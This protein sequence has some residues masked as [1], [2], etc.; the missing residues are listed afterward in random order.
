MIH[1]YASTIP[2]ILLY[3][4]LNIG[5]QSVCELFVSFVLLR[6]PCFG[7][8]K[9]PCKKCREGL[10]KKTNRLTV[11]L[12]QI[13]FTYINMPAPAIAA[14]LFSISSHGIQLHSTS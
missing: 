10:T 2:R 4:L 7:N 14:F 3:S 6:V 5:I 9:H 13:T 1:A 8:A 12:D 11:N